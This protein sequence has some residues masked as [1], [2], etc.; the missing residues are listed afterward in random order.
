MPWYTIGSIKSS[1]PYND[2]SPVHVQGRAATGVVAPFSRLLITRSDAAATWTNNVKVAEVK[3]YQ[4][5]SARERSFIRAL[6][7]QSRPLACHYGPDDPFDSG[8]CNLEITSVLTTFFPTLKGS[9]YLALM[10]SLAAESAFKP[11]SPYHLPH[12]AF[13]PS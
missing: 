10:V 6:E 3:I 9:P 8:I 7:A 1:L 4:W 5:R 12:Y 11:Y 13:S 2:L